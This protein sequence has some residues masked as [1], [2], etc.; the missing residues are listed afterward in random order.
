MMIGVKCLFE[1]QKAHGTVTYSV[2][3]Y[4]NIVKKAYS[5][6]G[7]IRFADKMDGFE[8]L[9]IWGRK[10][11]KQITQNP[12]ILLEEMQNEAQLCKR[13]HWKTII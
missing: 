1:I 5:R 2:N 8:D 12:E 7:K 9:A 10:W 4:M 3:I 13:K 11:L 6:L